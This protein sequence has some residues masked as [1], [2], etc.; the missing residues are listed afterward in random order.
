MNLK[1]KIQVKKERVNLVIN[2]IASIREADEKARKKNEKE[3][4]K[5]EKKGNKRTK[6]VGEKDIQKNKKRTSQELREEMLKKLENSKL[7]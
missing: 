6:K 4:A 5:K 3:F 2:R 1:K 7:K